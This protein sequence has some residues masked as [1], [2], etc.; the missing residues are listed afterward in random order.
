M[1]ATGGFG[2][3]PVGGGADRQVDLAEAQLQGV[4][5]L[6]PSWCT[7]C[8]AASSFSSA[9]AWT[10]HGRAV[11]VEVGGALP[12]SIGEPALTCGT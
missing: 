4:L 11:V 6:P 8:P 12:S 5:V 3:E 10:P 2:I 1:G 7:S 9:R